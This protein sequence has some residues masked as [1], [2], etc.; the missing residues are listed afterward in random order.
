MGSAG[1]LARA[2][3]CTRSS[4]DAG[5]DARAPVMTPLARL[6]GQRIALTG[7]ISVADFMAEALGHPVHGYYRRATAIGRA[8]DFVTAPEVSQVFGELIGA[9]LAERWL[10]LGRPDPVLLVELGP[11]RGTLLA[12][13]L[14]ATRGVP[15]FHAA[16]RPHLVEIHPA[17]REAQRQALQPYGGAVAAPTWHERLADV[18]EGSLLL[19]ANEFF[20]ALPVRQLQ[21][22]PHGWAERMVGLDAQGALDFA[23]APGPTPLA[24]MLPAAVR[25]GAHAPGTMVEVSPSAVSLAHDVAQRI[26]RDRGAALIIDY[27][28]NQSGIGATLQAVRGHEK[29]DVLDRPGETDLSAHVDFEALAR[30]AREAGAEVEGPV[31]QG[32]FLAALGIELRAQALAARATPEQR[33]TVTKAIHRLIDPAEMGTLFQALAIGDPLTRAPEGFAPTPRP[34]APIPTQET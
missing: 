19:V 33:E 34:S 26:V 22:T 23:L 28:R 15:G 10:A 9:W 5:K 12:D 13:A 11:G 4:H 27:G 21:R 2:F 3:S 30:A 31:A 29:V 1:I 14:R 8:G 7:P 20:D 24:L 18:P 6:I 32:A 16:L 17:L 25:E